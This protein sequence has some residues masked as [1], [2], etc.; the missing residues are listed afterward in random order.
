MKFI[1]TKEI[2]ELIDCLG[3]FYKD[4]ITGIEGVCDSVNVPLNGEPRLSLQPIDPN[5]LEIKTSYWVDF[6]N[7]KKLDKERAREPLAPLDYSIPL[8]AKV[9]DTLFGDVG[10]LIS[11]NFCINGCV[12]NLINK[13]LSKDKGEYVQISLHEERLEVIDTKKAESLKKKKSGLLGLFGSKKKEEE[14]APKKRG[15]PN[16]KRIS[17][18]SK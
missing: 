3:Y 16:E 8:G 15:G 12:I 18:Y 14:P 4:K 10:F 2:Q 5:N 6:S 9:K 1:I 13:G 17:T 7:A 11:K